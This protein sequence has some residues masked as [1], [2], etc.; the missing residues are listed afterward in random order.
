[1]RHPATGE[2]VH[3]DRLVAAALVAVLDGQEWAVYQGGGT[4][5]DGKTVDERLESTGF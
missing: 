3:D 4:V 5:T 2:P 1:M